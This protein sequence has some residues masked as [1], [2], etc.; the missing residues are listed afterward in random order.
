MGFIT[1]TPVSPSVHQ[2]A[3]ITSDPGDEAQTLQPQSLMNI[4]D[5]DV[6]VFD[7]V[8]ELNGP[9]EGP[10]LQVNVYTEDDDVYTEDNN[11]YTETLTL[12][13]LCAAS[14]PRHPDTVPGRR[15]ECH[16]W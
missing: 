11:V 7:E 15:A 13:P 8:H 3:L 4:A 12:R 6:V 1:H 14:H 16:H 9:T 2:N 10:A 5:M